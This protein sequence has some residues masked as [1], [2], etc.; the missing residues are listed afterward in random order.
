MA[1]TVLVGRTAG[2][3]RAESYP[4]RPIRLLVGL[5]PGGVQDLFAR[6]LAERLSVRLGAPVVVENRPGAGTN[7][8]TE[9][10]VRAAPDGYTLLLVGVPN[11]INASL[12]TSLPFDFARDIAPVAPLATTPEV[13]L[14]HPA[15]PITT[16]PELIDHAKTYPGTLNIASPGNGTGP[17]L[18]AELLKMMAGIDLVHIPFRGGAPAMTELLAGRVQLLFIAPAVALSHL[19]AGRVRALAVT[20]AVSCPV[21]PD[22]PP[23]NRFLPGFESGGFFGIGVPVR[24]SEQ[25]VERLNRDINAVLAQTEVEQRIRTEGAIV[26]RGT[27]DDL[28]RRVALETEKWGKVIRHAHLQPS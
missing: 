14:A 16:V 26:W 22:V 11:A 6:L 3:A 7:I 10:V 2:P 4:S 20:S 5:A 9:A 24:T 25:V 13:L 18:S 1:G 17:H 28:R 15:L 8:A 12:Y 19:G 23:L 21:L 27:A